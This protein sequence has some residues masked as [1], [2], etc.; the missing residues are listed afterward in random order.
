MM[1]LLCLSKGLAGC[2]YKSCND[3]VSFQMDSIIAA[4]EL[5]PSRAQHEFPLHKMPKS[6]AMGQKLAP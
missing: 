2:D 6:V 4:F 5:T 3:T 1:S